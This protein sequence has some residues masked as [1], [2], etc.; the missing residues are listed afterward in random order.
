M[1]CDAIRD[2]N[3]TFF[4]PYRRPYLDLTTTSLLRYNYYGAECASLN[5]TNL[6]EKVSEELPT[7]R[8]IMLGRR[9]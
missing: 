8:K 3:A 7:S 5:L 6:Y 2:A 9:G 4:S 1:R